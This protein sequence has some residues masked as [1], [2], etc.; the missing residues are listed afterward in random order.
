MRIAS[1]GEILWDVFGDQQRLGGAPFNFAAHAARLGHEVVFLSAVGDDERGHEAIRRARELN[2]STEYLHVAP[3]APTGHVTVE[4]DAAGAPSFTIHRPA[5]YD[6]F[7]LSREE[8]DK[9]AL[10]SPEVVAYGTLHQTVPA[11]K[12][13]V[14][15]LLDACPEARRFY[16]VNLRKDS[17]NPFLLEDLML[18]A[19][20]VKL[21]REELEEINRL[22]G[23]SFPSI[24]KACEYWCGRYGWEVVTVTLG[25]KGCVALSGDEWVE[26]PGYAVRVVDTVG[27]GDAYSAAFIHGL[28]SG[29]PL[30][31]VADFANRVGAVV[32]SKPGAVPEWTL[33]ECWA[34]PR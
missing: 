18:E 33:E 2:V 6:H 30:E 11:V 13:Q 25:E 9:L 17:Y 19:T 29:W 34:L 26:A 7:R 31:K 3:E 16:D 12:A 27:A 15:L 28:A 5:A 14:R 20:V 21:N 22:F 23:L 10:F 32:A 8:L 24:R 4:L 1:I